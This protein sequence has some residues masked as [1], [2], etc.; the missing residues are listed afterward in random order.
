MPGEPA[1]SLI[2]DH[3]RRARTAQSKSNRVEDSHGPVLM[4]DSSARTRPDQALND[5]QADD[6]S[7]IKL[8]QMQANVVVKTNGSRRVRHSWH[9]YDTHQSKATRIRNE[10]RSAIHSFRLNRFERPERGKH[11]SSGHSMRDSVVST[12][13]DDLKF[14]TDFQQCFEQFPL[15]KV[16]ERPW[17]TRDAPIEKIAGATS[18]HRLENLL[19]DDLDSLFLA[20]DPV[21][22]MRPAD[23]ASTD[24]KLSSPE[25][26]L[27]R[28]PDGSLVAELD[29][30][31]TSW[32][33]IRAQELAEANKQAIA[34]EM[35]VSA[36][37][38]AHKRAA[39][40]LAM[41]LSWLRPP[42][43]ALKTSKKLSN[44]RRAPECDTIYR[45]SMPV[46][47]SASHL[48]PWTIEAT[49]QGILL[50]P[51]ALPHNNVKDE[52]MALESRTIVTVKSAD[53]SWLDE[54]F[55]PEEETIEA[56]G[57][58]DNIGACCVVLAEHEQ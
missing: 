40:C 54:E 14:R 32:S 29:A 11:T 1:K 43:W 2:E 56:P 42:P 39:D 57:Y 44:N 55:L 5:M 33:S 30:A 19:Y 52:A 17:E 37:V 7:N 31:E 53:F 9:G 41:K 23:A 46:A 35:P 10:T 3:Q 50:C 27:P 18:S 26:L 51:S 6:L 24:T 16:F 8:P 25:I 20:A 4:N 58:V 45:N 22:V 21:G 38:N 34:C 13:S 36:P 47:S 12:L 49:E 28:N 48:T 15:E